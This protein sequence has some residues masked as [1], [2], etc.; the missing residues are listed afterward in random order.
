MKRLLI[1]IGLL[2]FAAAPAMA[3]ENQPP[4][5]PSE[6]QSAAA[7][8]SGKSGSAGWIT[9]PKTTNAR[10]VEGGGLSGSS[11]NELDRGNDGQLTPN[12]AE[13]AGISM[14]EADTDGDGFLSRDEF[15]A[16]R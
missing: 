4:S 14:A 16:A 10:E 12:E 9:G 2:G 3:Q 13:A 15:N 6:A 1:A 7:N 5:V 8:E 11:F